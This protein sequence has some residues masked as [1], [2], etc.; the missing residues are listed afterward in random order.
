MQS[1]M[2]LVA[3]VLVGV[4]AAG[5]ASGHAPS[6][7]GWAIAIHG[8]AGAIR[9]GE[10]PELEPRYREAMRRVLDEGKRRLAAGD[11]ALDVCESL[12]RMLEDDELFNAGRGAVLTER[13][14]AE[15]DAAIMDGPTMRAGAVAG[16]KTVRHPIALARLV[17]ERTPH[18]L[19]IGEGAE[20]F[21][22][23]AGVERVSNE[24]FITPRRREQLE[25]ELK[26]KASE[27]ASAD[28]PA[29]REGDQGNPI[30]R[31]EPTP[32]ARFGT[33]GVVALDRGGR[34]AAATSTGGM[35]AKR[36]GRV[37]DAPLIGSGTYANATVAVSC[38]GTGE[39]FIRHA[40]ASGIAARMELAGESVERAASHYVFGALNAGDGG[41]IAVDRRGRIAM[42]YSSAG[43]YR[44]TADSNGR[45]EV[46]IWEE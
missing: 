35:T 38:T 14:E 28:S 39:Q 45:D 4:L 26:R 17:M 11:A 31:L 27:K 12:V 41:L 34:L 42:P 2:M 21:A 9:K 7:G 20:V 32:D 40:V 33:V 46:R 1:L 6:H 24:W 30:H 29:Q 3:M 43:M 37:G 16:V 18:V 25:R 22:T 36:P 8:G 44:A 23:E 10:T 15:L 19:L 13:G 5:C